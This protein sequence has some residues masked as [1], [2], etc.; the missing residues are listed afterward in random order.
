MPHSLPKIVWNV[1]D[2]NAEIGITE[3]SRPHWD[4]PGALTFVTFRLADSMPKAVVQRW[5]SEQRRWLASRGYENFDLTSDAAFE[6]LP[7]DLRH[8]FLKMKKQGWHRSLDQCHGKCWM[9]QP[10][11]AQMMAETLLHFEAERYDMERFV[12]MPN[13]VHLLVQMRAGLVLRKQCESWTRYS[14]REINRQLGRSGEFWQSEPFDHVVR[15]LAQFEYL[16]RYIVENP[17]KAR[18][19]AGESLLWI[20]A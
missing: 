6:Q 7:K 15:S 3:R 11:M 18:L 2:T 10:A 17:V 19:G 20:R 4:Q 14:G 9:R 13:H 16:R 8:A 12:I 1:L 5:L